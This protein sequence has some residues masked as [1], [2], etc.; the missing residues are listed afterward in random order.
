M[1]RLTRI[2]N[3]H[4]PVQLQLLTPS[5]PSGVR[6]VFNVHNQEPGQDTVV[7]LLFTPRRLGPRLERLEG[8][9]G[10]EGEGDSAAEGWYH[11]GIFARL[12]HQPGP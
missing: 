12:T 10:L 9:R 7:W 2:E 1:Q 5:K 8:P 6:T 3:L 11:R 4:Y